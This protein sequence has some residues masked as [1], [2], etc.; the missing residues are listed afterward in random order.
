MV[1]VPVDAPRLSD[2]AAPPM[3]KV[4]AVS[5]IRSKLEEPVTTEVVKVGVVPNTTEP[6]PVSSV[7]VEAKTED[8]PEEIRFLGASVRTNLEAVRPSRLTVPDKVGLSIRG[9]LAKTRA[10]V[11]VSSEIELATIAEVPE[12]ERFIVFILIQEIDKISKIVNVMYAGCRNRFQINLIELKLCHHA[13]NGIKRI[14]M[15]LHR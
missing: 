9:L 1:V 3:F 14:F 15:P 6:E 13:I 11:P 10:P 2:V 5:L 8:A 7:W 4:V 12:E